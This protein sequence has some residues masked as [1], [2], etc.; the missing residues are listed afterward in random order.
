MGVSELWPALKLYVGMG[1]TGATAILMTILWVR[2]NAYN[3]KINEERIKSEVDHSKDMMRLQTDHA[4]EIISLV[5]Q[6][7]Q[8]ISS[9]NKTLDELVSKG[10]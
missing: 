6:Y 2:S 8:Q 7:D 4:K 3:K 5:R 9:V 10:D 1:A